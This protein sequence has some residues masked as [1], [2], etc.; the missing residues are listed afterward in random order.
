MEHVLENEQIIEEGDG[1]GGWV[2]THHNV[3]ISAASVT[4][5]DVEDQ[6]MKVCLYLFMMYNIELPFSLLL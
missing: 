3:D 6:E 5:K 2:D 1:D 4:E